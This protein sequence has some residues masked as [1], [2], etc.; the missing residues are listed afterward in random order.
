MIPD[1]QPI[2]IP[3]FL[4]R[5]TNI[6]YT[7]STNNNLLAFGFRVLSSIQIS[8]VYMYFSGVAGSPDM[9]D[10]VCELREASSIYGSPTSSVL[11]DSTLDSPPVVGVNSFSNFSG[12]NL[13][14]GNS[15]WLSVRNLSLT[16]SS[17][18]VSV[19]RSCGY[20]SFLNGLG[21]VSVALSS[22]GGS[23]WSLSNEYMLPLVIETAGPVSF[24][25]IVVGINHF[26]ASAG[27]FLGYR[28]TPSVDAEVQGIV[29]SWAGAGSSVATARLEVLDGSGSTVIWNSASM[30]NYRSAIS[31][32]FSS[33]TYILQAN[34][35]YIV[36]LRFVS[37]TSSSDTIAAR[38]FHVGTNWL[39]DMGLEVAYYTGTNWLFTT[40]RWPGLSLLVRSISSSSAYARQLLS[41]VYR[42]VW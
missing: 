12:V 27:S 38:N 15:Y 31:S 32:Y 6:S 21:G 24:G 29:A 13:T 17:N 2:G 19:L 8:K 40:T 14:P 28:F 41:S 20:W 37:G 10:I 9:S 26:V 22:N 39:E 42:G 5:G 4:I 33:S 3:G 1:N 25:A 16:P 30:S 36:G 7:L 11:D 23:S 18:N 34:Q 35:T